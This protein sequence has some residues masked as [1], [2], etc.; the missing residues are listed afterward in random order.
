MDILELVTNALESLN[1]PCIYGWYDENLSET[2]ITFLEFD[3]Q[4]EEYSDDEATSIEHYI[5][6]DIWTKDT[7]ESQTIKKQVKELLKQNGF[8]YQNGQDLFEIENQMWH[9]PQR[10]LIVEYLE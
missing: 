8:I 2:H 7:N 5:Q 10:F 3:N 1:I 9:I 6:V 4:E